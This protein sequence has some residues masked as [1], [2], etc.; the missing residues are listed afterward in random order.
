MMYLVTAA[1]AASRITLEPSVSPYNA[2]RSTWTLDS[3]PPTEQLIKITTALRLNED[4]VALLEKTLYEVSDPR[5]A[6]YGKHKTA[7]QVGDILAIPQEQVDRVTNFWKTHGAAAVEVSPSKHLMSIAISVADVETALNTRLA[8]F[9]NPQVRSSIVRATSTYSVPAALAKDVSMVGEL[10]QFPRPRVLKYADSATMSSTASWPN[11]CTSS[12]CANAVTPSVLA[13]RYNFPA[14]QTAVSG[15]S[16]AVAEFQGQ[17]YKPTDLTYFNTNC[18]TNVGVDTNIGT[19]GNSAGVEAELDIEYIKSVAPATP[20]TD[21]Y[22]SSYSL[23]AWGQQITGLSSPPL[24]HSVSYGNDEAQQTSTE[25]MLSVNTVFMQAGTQGLSILFASGDQGVCGREGCGLFRHSYHPDF[26]AASPY[27]TAVGGT[28]FA[29]AGVI[30]A[31]KTWADGGG[32]FSDTF[33]IPSYQASAVA[34]YLA[35]PDANLPSSS[36]YNASG[37]AYPDVAALAG[38]QNPYC[39]A[40]S[41]R[42]AGVGGTSASCPVVAAIFSR[43][44]GVRL[45][46]NGSPLG[47]LN[48]F[49]YQ[50]PSAFNDVT[51]G[52]NTGGGRAGG[53]TATTGWDAATGW[54]T[55]DYGKLAALV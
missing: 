28:D 25:Y 35:N 5:H 8:T 26:P 4:R 53:F 32:G 34:A 9:T 1:L 2:T 17:Y 40:T 15:N 49:I 21:I 55:P 19:N 31:E 10:H 18:G 14:T 30:G 11:T 36:L 13:T 51:Q 54:G 20:L 37:R 3:Y 24:I 39:V 33:A 29:T 41:G 16:M 46:K 23:M 6:E 12:S 43:L 48:P 38:V 22:S 52:T 45:G 7:A 44:N 47:F 27:V 50:N 42:F